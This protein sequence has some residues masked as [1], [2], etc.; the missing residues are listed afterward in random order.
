MSTQIEVGGVSRHFLAA[1]NANACREYMTTIKEARTFVSV[2]LRHYPMRDL[3]T[4]E[5][6]YAFILR[7]VLQTMRAGL[8]SRRRI[9]ET[10]CSTVASYA[11]SLEH[12]KETAKMKGM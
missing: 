9:Q 11:Y 3:K 1:K 6:P 2:T 12:A 5:P 8:T 10:T 4:P 7:E